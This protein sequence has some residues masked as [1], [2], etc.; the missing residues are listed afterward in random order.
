MENKLQELTQ[1]IYSEGIE[2]ANQDA[3][4]IIEGAQ[5]KADEITKAAKNEASEIISKAQANANEIK[6]NGESEIRIASK[7][8]I[9]KLKQQIIN[10]I[11]VKA[12]DKPVKDAF[13]D[14]AFVGSLIQKVASSF[15]NNAKLVLP[16]ADQ[17]KLTAYFNDNTSKE[18]M[19][20][21]QISFDE[22][23]KVGF[24]ISPKDANYIISFTDE[25]FANYFKGF[26]RS[27]TIQLLFGE[28]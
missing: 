24:K 27:K 21:L 4:R 11:S 6:R 1:K 7:Q 20:S 12:I 28:E 19:K 15:N 14:K 17:D 26:M 3:I 16:E 9:S 23:I 10:M 13:D 2:K 5:K 25:D 22:N 8:A 18:L